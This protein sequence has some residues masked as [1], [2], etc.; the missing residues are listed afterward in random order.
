MKCGDAPV[1]V[2][3]RDQARRWRD[4]DGEHIDV[5]GL[6]PPEPLVEILRLVQSID[7][8]TNVIVHHDREPML[9]YPELAQIGWQAERIPAE[10]GE[11]RLRLGRRA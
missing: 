7:T 6:P 2:R 10:P 11:V 5:R 3:M 4:G 9:L 8:T 1:V